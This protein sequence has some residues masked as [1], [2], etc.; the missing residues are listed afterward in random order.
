MSA[1]FFLHRLANWLTTI[2]QVIYW[3]WASQPIVLASLSHCVC[4]STLIGGDTH[5]HTQTERQVGRQKEWDWLG[6]VSTLGVC[7]WW[8][9]QGN[10]CALLSAHRW[11]G[12]EWTRQSRGIGRIETGLVSQYIWGHANYVPPEAQGFYFI[13]FIIQYN[14]VCVAPHWASEICANAKCVP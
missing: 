12:M 8:L 14:I 7:R 10:L 6:K 13:L 5:T 2:G 3:L 4:C 11:D 1:H 9:H